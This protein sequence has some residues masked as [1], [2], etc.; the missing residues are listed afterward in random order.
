MNLM[1]KII[2]P[3]LLTFFI[4]CNFTETNKTTNEKKWIYI[5]IGKSKDNDSDA[6]Y[7]E[8]SIEHL[9]L[10]KQNDNLEK[11]IMIS[12]T[13]YNDEKDSI[14]K[15]VT[16]EGNQN[17]TFYYKIKDIN[18]IEILKNDPINTKVKLMDE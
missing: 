18:Y 17:G 5:E 9:D 6:K 14:V 13:R 1:R 8:I 11:I 10:I 7:G 3:V 15:D 16:D 2:L 4:S 12:N